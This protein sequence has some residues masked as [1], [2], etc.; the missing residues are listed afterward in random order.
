[1]KKKQVAM[2]AGLGIFAAGAL[3]VEAQGVDTTARLDALERE[4]RALRADR[5]IEEE[6]RLS[7][8]GYGELHYNNLKGSGG[9]SDKELIDFHRF[10]LFVG[11]SFSDRIR[12]QSE[13]E[14][15]HAIAGDD[16]P[17]EIEL[18]Q[19][20]IDFDLNQSHTARAGLFLLPVGLLNETHEPTRF[21]GVERNSVEKNIIPTTWWEGGAGLY[22]DVVGNLT[23]GA[24]LHSGLMTSAD[25]SYSVRA[26]RQK[27]GKAVASDPA[28]TVALNWR[29]GGAT[30]GGSIQYQSDITQSSDPL[31]G[32]AWLGELHADAI[33]GPVALRG[34]V[35]E[36]SLSGDGPEEIGADRQM[37]WYIEPS[38]RLCE[39][40][41]LFV[42]YGEW[43]NTAGSAGESGGKTQTDIGVNW[44]PHAQVVVKAD[45][46]WQ[47][48][49][50]GKDQSGFNLGLGYQF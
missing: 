2:F 15:E 28:A 31:A 12:F 11:Y 4:V 1:M 16:Q 5:P 34:L 24:Y 50:N 43:D 7:L 23:Y 3:M 8:G 41:G 26:G 36:W 13:L 25:D 20:F 48:N 32:D 42:R 18:E 21:Y 44:W 35:A 37:G 40:V 46:Q 29:Q 9:A 45:Y 49:E 6:Q 30:F 17:G 47:D 27:V 10:V 14:L 39:P 33:C 19:A 22:G 38:Y